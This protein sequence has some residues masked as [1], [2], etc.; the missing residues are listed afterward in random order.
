MIIAPKELL[1][2]AQERHYAIPA[3]NFYNL[4]GLFAVL[5]AAEEEQAPII[6]EIYHVYYPF[7]HQKVICS[8]VQETLRS[9]RIHA[10]LHLD[11]AT[12]QQVLMAA[13]KDGFQSV[14]VDGSTA[15][16]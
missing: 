2:D 15:S 16:L 5:E 7:L 4:D 11:H 6:V 1:R 3:F 13:I 14:M 8:A 10:Y 12:D 9:A